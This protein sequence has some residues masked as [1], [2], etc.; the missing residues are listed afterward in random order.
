MFQK[1]LTDIF[2]AI[3]DV[4]KSKI[5]NGNLES[6]TSY[7]N[8]GYSNDLPTENDQSEAS[9]S[10]RR[11]PPLELDVPKS[12]KHHKG[13]SPRLEVNTSSHEVQPSSPRR[14]KKHRSKRRPTSADDN[15]GET[16]PSPIANGQLDAFDASENSPRTPTETKPADLISPESPVPK[17][18]VTE[19]P[20]N[21]SNELP[22]VRPKDPNRH[23]RVVVDVEPPIISAEV[24]LFASSHDK[25]KNSLRVS[26]PMPRSKSAASLQRFESGDINAEVETIDMESNYLS[27]SQSKLPSILKQP[28]DS[29]DHVIDMFQAGSR[30]NSA[31]SSKPSVRIDDQV[32]YADDLVTFSKNEP[33]TSRPRSANA[34]HPRPRSANAK[35]PRSATNGVAMGYSSGFSNDKPTGIANKALKKM[36]QTTQRK[37]SPHIKTSIFTTIFC[38]LFAGAAALYFS[39]KARTALKN[40]EYM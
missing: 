21:I 18:E 13:K 29:E 30:P 14:S 37:V 19:S 22:S 32:T 3:A 23:V 35:R 40:G 36:G 4:V 33:K 17:I 10:S 11:L 16:S 12:H 5:T 27:S 1:Y 9:N 28:S 24:D 2:C 6:P 38:G 31:S 15:S 26:S 7:L 34:K 20:S 39:L 25:P 8:N